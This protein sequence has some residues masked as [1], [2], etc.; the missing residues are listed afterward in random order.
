MRWA[1]GFRYPRCEGADHYALRD[2]PRKAFQCTGCRHQVSLIAE[3]I[4]QGTKLPLT[5]WF[6]AINLISQAKTGLSAFA[7]KRQLDVSYLTAWLI[8]RKLMQVMAD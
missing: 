3:T 2:G 5:T 4:F 8:H 7:M 1:E 6:L